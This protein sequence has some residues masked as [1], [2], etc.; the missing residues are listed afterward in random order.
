MTF[1]HHEMLN[2]RAGEVLAMIKDMGVDD[3]CLK[4]DTNDLDDNPN[5]LLEYLKHQG[6]LGNLI[7]NADH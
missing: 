2:K 1:I 3:Y 7:L 4:N 5:F 6:N